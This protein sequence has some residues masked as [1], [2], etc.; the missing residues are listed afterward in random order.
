MLKKGI[1]FFL[2]CIGGMGGDSDNL[3][4]PIAIILIGALLM[5]HEDW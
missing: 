3:L 1:G 5:T 2:A 4:I